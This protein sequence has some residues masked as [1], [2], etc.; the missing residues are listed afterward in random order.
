MT[1]ILRPCSIETEFTVAWHSQQA[2]LDA[3]D[4]ARKQGARRVRFQDGEFEFDSVE[5]YLK[6]RNLILIGIAQQSGPQRAASTFT[7]QA[8]AKCQL[9]GRAPA[10]V[11]VSIGCWN[12]RN[13]KSLQP[14]QSARHRE[15]LNGKQNHSHR[16][17][18]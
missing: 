8:P 17:H 11:N 4:A 5:D 1:M 12:Q 10:D 13:S 9:T 16:L 3:L 7:F 15:E 14:N 18:E 2:D 6:L